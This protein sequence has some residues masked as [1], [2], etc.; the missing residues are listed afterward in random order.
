M[1]SIGLKGHNNPEFY[2]MVGLLL[3]M[4]QWQIREHHGELIHEYYQHPL[5]EWSGKL[6]LHFFALFFL[7]CLLYN[8]LYQHSILPEWSMTAINYFWYLFL[9]IFQYVARTWY[10]SFFLYMW[11]E[12]TVFVPYF[13]LFVWTSMVLSE[14]TSS[15]STKCNFVLKDVMKLWFFSQ[16]KKKHILNLKV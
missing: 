15:V 8:R 5:K 11:V 4:G 12:G 1:L 7:N 6:I 10:I 16:G 2:D 14:Y 3:A 13:V 9:D